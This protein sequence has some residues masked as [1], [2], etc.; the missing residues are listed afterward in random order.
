M[1]VDQVLEDLLEDPAF[2]L[3]DISADDLS[4]MGVDQDVQVAAFLDGIEVCSCGAAPLAFTNGGL[5][6]A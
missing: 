5:H 2:V 6:I 1:L 3:G 4:D